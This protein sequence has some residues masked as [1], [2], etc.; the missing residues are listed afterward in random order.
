M[1]NTIQVYPAIL[2]QEASEIQRKLALVK[3]FCS[4]VHLDIMD[5]EFVSNTTVN[6]PDLL[7]TINWGAVKISLHLMI[8]NP[9]LYL[10]KWAL[11]AVEL[12]IIHAEASSNLVEEIRLIKQLGKKA[13][14][15]INPHTATYTLADVINDLDAVLVMGVEPGYST[16]A[17]N[18]D[19]LQKISYLRSLRSDLLIMVDGG[20]NSAT[21]DSI[22]KA[23]ADVLCANSFIFKSSNIE[24]SINNLR[25][26]SS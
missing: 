22:I 18:A 26:I 5:G 21:K 12:M 13:G 10:K 7:A 3:P 23:G 20:V 8:K 15:A 19:V 24:D 11:P 17:F 6:D 2:E 4:M 1:S 25:T 14:I 9:V 16:Q